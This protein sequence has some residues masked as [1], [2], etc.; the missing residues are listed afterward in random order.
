MR[1][2]TGEK[3]YNCTICD[4]ALL[5]T[6]N[7][8]THRCI[9]SSEIFTKCEVCNLLQVFSELGHLNSHMWIH[10]REKSYM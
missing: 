5:R 1:I 6:G 10:T 3:L 8:K 4:K 9:H 7:L 2:H